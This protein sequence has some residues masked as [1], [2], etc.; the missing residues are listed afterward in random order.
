M[1]SPVLRMAPSVMLWFAQALGGCRGRERPKETV[2]TSAAHSQPASGSSHPTAEPAGP[3]MKF[4]HPSN[5]KAAEKLAEFETKRDAAALE[6]ASDTLLKVVLSQERDPVARR[7]LRK[8]TSML[9]LRLFAAVDASIDPTFDPNELPRS[10]VVPPESDGI[11]YPPGVDPSA[12]A[13][14]AARRE[15]ERLIRE[16]EDKTNN[17]NLQLMLR[18]YDRTLSPRGENFIQGAYSR[19]AEDRKELEDAVA[20]QIHNTQRADRLRK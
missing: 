13:D 1:R 15:Y 9:W 16:N 10:S 4:M 19:S 18:R 11:L 3:K 20:L 14:P 12:L 5:E 17:Y 2:S 6:V 8:E 7:A